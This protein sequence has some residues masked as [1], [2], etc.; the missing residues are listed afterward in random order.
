MCYRDQLRLS[1]HPG[2]F[3]IGNASQTAD[4]KKNM[5]LELVYSPG[6]SH[7]TAVRP[8]P[9]LSPIAS[10]ILKSLQNHIATIQQS[11]VTPKQ[12]LRFISETWD[13][14][15]GLEEE[16]RMLEFCGVTKLTLTEDSENDKKPSLRARCTLLSRI[17]SGQQKQQQKTP[18]RKRIPSAMTEKQKRIDIDFSIKTRIIPNT[19][20]NAI[21]TMH[22]DTD[23]TAS[24]VYGFG[25]GSP[26]SGK[27]GAETGLSE[28]EMR[29]ILCKELGVLVGGGGKKSDSRSDSVSQ[30]GNGVWWRAVKALD[31]VVF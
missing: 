27:D 4:E 31:G 20:D 12:L 5:P 8:T 15:L 18:T 23:V 16:A 22:F 6:A 30:L 3:S 17:P 1:F 19:G 28:R 24:K 29:E 25:S 9:Q 2:A 13:R 26:G 21:G 7:K 11:T 14:I 10:L